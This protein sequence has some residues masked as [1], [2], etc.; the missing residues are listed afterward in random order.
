M[1]I[2]PFTMSVV[3]GS[4]ACQAR[5]PFCVSSFTVPNG[6]TE[7][8]EPINYKNWHQACSLAKQSGVTTILLTG[9]GEPTLFPS[10]ISEVL[11]QLKPYD[12]PIIELQT[13]GLKLINDDFDIHLKEWFRLG[14]RTISISNVGIDKELNKQIYTP[15]KEY[16]DL[17]KLI[18]KLH[19]I[20]F[21][22]RLATVM[23]KNGVDTVSK[24]DE[25][26]Q[27]AKKNKVEQIKIC[28]VTKPREVKNENGRYSLEWF[29]TGTVDMVNL[30]N[31][32]NYLERFGVKLLIL[33]HGATVYD[34]HG[35]NICYSNCLTHSSDPEA[36]RQ[37]IC[38]PNGSLKYSWEYEGATIL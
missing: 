16:I 32:G 8:F 19:S 3:V 1:Q 37:L 11:F 18:E 36:I 28:P 24:V 9:K 25:L 20:G 7:H 14:L 10:Q 6:V 33:P 15:N 2:K 31:I 21:S 22:V 30:I 35:Q 4:A 17:E 23:I 34:F 29:N 26:I 13:N 38:F 12:F 5:C 27:F